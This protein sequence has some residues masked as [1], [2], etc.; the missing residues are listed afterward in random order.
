MRGPKTRVR[1]GTHLKLISWNTNR[2]KR[3][4]VDQAAALL[5]R[6]PDVV[7]LQEITRTTIPLLAAR[8]R[9]GG[10]EHVAYSFSGPTG[11]G[12]RAFGVLIASRLPLVAE[13]PRL[14][15]PWAEKALS[16]VVRSGDAEVEIH[17]VHVPPG[18][19]NGWIKVEVLEGITRGLT[20]PS[21]RHRI[22]C[23][24]FNTPQHETHAGEIVTWAQ[25]IIGDR[26]VLRNRLRG[27]AGA[28]WDAAERAMLAGSLKDVFRT[29]HG[30]NAE[31]ASWFLERNGRLV[32][33]RFD[34]IMV[35]TDIRAV[36]CE[37]RHQW[38]LDGLS[39]HSAIEAN[40]EI[41]SDLA[42]RL[43]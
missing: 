16:V 20:P 26:I 41:G 32:G 38:R 22:L 36:G 1:R 42:S 10:L 29:V 6:R 5:S 21:P 4:A 19:T 24:D 11:T 39:D 8:L 23:G 13:L 35:S 31:E 14:P 15:I 12:P 18:S 34:H 7:A 43:G 40:L 25:R 37:Y 3:A 9:D 28:R 27:G 30:Y 33:R 2:R 17:T